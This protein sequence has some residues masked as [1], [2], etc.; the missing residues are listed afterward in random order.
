MQHLIADVGG[1]DM[2][3]AAVGTVATPA[4]GDL[5]NSTNPPWKPDPVYLAASDG[6][7]LRG[8]ACQKFDG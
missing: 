7:G 1:T 6:S 8:D 4:H 2:R 5:V 3:C